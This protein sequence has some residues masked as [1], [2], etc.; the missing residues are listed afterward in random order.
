MPSESEIAAALAR[1]R[2]VQA[3]PHGLSNPDR[4]GM[5]M[6]IYKSVLADDAFHDQACD[7][8]TLAAAYAALPGRQSDDHK[9][10]LAI[11]RETAYALDAR[12]GSEKNEKL[13]D[14]LCDASNS[15]VALMMF[16][17]PAALPGPTA[18]G[19]AAWERMFNARR[20]AILFGGVPAI[21]VDAV[22]K[23]ELSAILAERDREL[24]TLRADLADL[25]PAVR[26]WFCEST[27]YTEKVAEDA[28]AALDRIAGEG[29]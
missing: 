3:I 17:E 29:K 28:R 10:H 9:A 24:A 2:R 26:A 6:D 22:M 13:R 16:L 18:D 7:E 11:A 20:E 1:Y 5:L 21:E 19:E 14:L 27:G 23:A 4:I 25:V 8:Q 15:I 12:A